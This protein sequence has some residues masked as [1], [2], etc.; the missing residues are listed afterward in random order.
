MELYTDA[1]RDDAVAGMG[2]VIILDSGEKIEDRR[3][4]YGTYTSMEVE[5]FALLDGLRYARRHGTGEITVFSDCKPLIQKMRVPD[6]NDDEW[7]KRRRG[8][9]RLLNKFDSWELE[10]TP[11]SSNSNA[12][13]LAY[14]ALEDGRGA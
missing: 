7:Y 8:C 3:Y 9:H 11:R 13:R 6:G 5:Y 1:A 14:E 12:D 2:W 4:V 10:W